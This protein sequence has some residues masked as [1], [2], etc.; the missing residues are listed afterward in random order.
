MK[1]KYLLICVLV[2]DLIWTN[3]LDAAALRAL[4]LPDDGAP[5]EGNQGNHDLQRRNSGGPLSFCCNNGRIDPARKLSFES[6]RTF[7]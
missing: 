6:E 2:A 1:F 7:N 5:R 3:C 4:M